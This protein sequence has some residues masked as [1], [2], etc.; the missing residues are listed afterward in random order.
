MKRR[1]WMRTNLPV[2][3]PDM[4]HALGTT[5][6]Q[7]RPGLIWLYPLSVVAHKHLPSALLRLNDQSLEWLH[8]RRRLISLLPR[9]RRGCRRH[10]GCLPLL[11]FAAPKTAPTVLR[12]HSGMSSV[13]QVAAKAGTRCSECRTIQ[14]CS[15]WSRSFRMIEQRSLATEEAEFGCQMQLTP[16]RR[17]CHRADLASSIKAR[18]EMRI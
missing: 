8:I 18:C 15:G 2:H 5:L 14:Q 3:T 9:R 4:W 11:L 7:A 6:P 13:T 1:Q 17:R 16:V 12:L 10:A